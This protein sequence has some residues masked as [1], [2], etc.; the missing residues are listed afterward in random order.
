MFKKRNLLILLVVTIIA[1]GVFYRTY[2][3][4]MNAVYL[5]MQHSP[6]GEFANYAKFAFYIAGFM[7]RLSPGDNG[8]YDF[9]AEH[10]RLAESDDFERGRVYFHEGD[11][12]AAVKHLEEALEAKGPSESRL[13]WLAMAYMRL[14]EANNCLAQLARETDAGKVP[15][16]YDHR[17]HKHG[18]YCTLPIKQFHQ[19]DLGSSHAAALLTRLLDEYDSENRLYRWLLN[20]SYMTINRFPQGVPE[21]YRI[22]SEFIDYF[23]GER[24][25]QMEA[26]YSGLVFEDQAG[27]LGIDKLDSGKG[28]AVE[29]FDGDGFL[30]IVTGGSYSDVRYYRNNGGRGFVDA[31]DTAGLDGIYQTHIITAAD[32]DNDG[33][34]DLFFSAPFSHFRLFRNNRDGTFR[35]VTFKSGL[36]P[37][38]PEENQFIETWISAWGDVDNDGDLDLFLGQRAQRIPM[39]GGIYRKIPIDSRLYINER[40]Q[41]TDQTKAFGLADIVHNEGYVGAAFGDYDSDGYTDLFISSWS[42]TKSKMLK[43]INGKRFEYAPVVS[44]TKPGFMAAFLDVNHDGRLD[45]LQASMGLAETATNLVVYDG[46]QA[47]TTYENALFLN[48]GDRFVERSDM[49]RG[50]MPTGSMGASYGDI[51]NDGCQDF[52]FGTGDP[53]AWYVLPNLMFVSETDGARCSDYRDNI[54]MLNGFGT[55]Q[56]GHGIVFFDFDNDGDQDIYSSLGGMWP[57]DRWPNQMFV[58]KTELERTWV[59]I[60]L[61]GRAS[62]RFGVGALIKVIAVRK[63]GETL[64]RYYHM[65][66]KTGFGSAPYLAHIGLLN[67][68]RIQEVTVRWPVSGTERSYLDVPIGRL[69]LLDEDAGDP[70]IS[71]N[72]SSPDADRY[73]GY[74]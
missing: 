20:F 11:F 73:H 34:M 68:E 55:I 15:L 49:F 26:K 21:R 1:S 9:R 43:N 70:V 66:N 71:S 33:W 69:S 7:E 24:K 63:G 22:D 46:K 27:A 54:S 65:D 8:V 47:D 14:G 17:G 28:V 44:H 37:G 53:E 45:L 2:Q 39:F 13:F 5:E 19:D 35:D 29:D 60:R 3:G 18:E 56:K 61:R 25:A 57:G 32:Y 23:Y 38:P 50:N 41:F 64:T 42:R 40:G 36:L 6:A 31:T 74:P 72:T 51:N 4:S 10:A 67:A 48:T 52:Y 16:S 12:D 30:D 58:N 59:K 62:N